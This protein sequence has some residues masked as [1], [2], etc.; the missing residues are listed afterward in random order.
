MPWAFLLADDLNIY[1]QETKTEVY[2]K[3]IEANI[4]SLK[5]SIGSVIHQSVDIYIVIGTGSE[6]P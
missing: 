2:E 3:A 6:N 5:F 1:K 4:F